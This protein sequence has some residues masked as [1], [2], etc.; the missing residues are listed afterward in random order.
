MLDPVLNQV[1][2]QCLGAF[3]TL[4]VESLQ[5]EANEPSVAQQKNKLTSQYAMKPI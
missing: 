3:K 2:R 1:L 5:V 4:P